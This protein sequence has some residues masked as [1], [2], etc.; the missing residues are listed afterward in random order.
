MHAQEHGRT[1]FQKSTGL[2]ISHYFSAT[3]LRWILDNVPGVKEDAEAGH[4]LFGT[5]DSWLLW[6]LSLGEHHITDVTNASRTLL[7]NLESLQWDD[8]ILT[9]MKVPKVMLPKIVR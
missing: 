1:R 9:A 3:K 4:A 8:E 6:K 2:P 5:I 7:M